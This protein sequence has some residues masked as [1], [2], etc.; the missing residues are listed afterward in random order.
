MT[1]LD[2]ETIKAIESIEALGDF[3]HTIPSD[4][5]YTWEMEDTIEFNFNAPDPIPEVPYLEIKTVYCGE[6]IRINSTPPK[7][8]KQLR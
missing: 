1:I 7:Y 6:G 4:E 5:Y 8:R 3:L 2:F